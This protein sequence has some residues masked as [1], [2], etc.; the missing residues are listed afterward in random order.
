MRMKN[1][2]NKGLLLVLSLA[3]F[4]ACDFNADTAV[5]DGEQFA[6]FGSDSYFAFLLEPQETLTIE[7]SL[8][9][10]NLSDEAQT[11][12]FTVLTDSSTAQ[13]GVHYDLAS[14]SVT[15][16]AGAV[17]ASFPLTM[18]KAA[19]DNPVSLVLSFGGP[20]FNQTTTVTIQNP[21]RDVLLGNYALV[22]PWY[23]GSDA[24]FAQEVVIGD[25]VSDV[26]A[27]NMLEADTD[28]TLRVTPS[29]DDNI[30]NIGV[31]RQNAW[32]SGTFGQV[33]VE[34]PANGTFN[35]TTGVIELTLGHFIPD[36]RTF[37]AHPL[38][39]TKTN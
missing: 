31:S 17:S 28:I 23:F 18:Y 11:V 25:V 33:T 4:T 19:L 32:T 1:L 10:N 5:Y 38:T 9:T 8:V 29:G 2:Y 21:I 6:R 37:G 13:A 7:V 20:N 30:Y 27:P 22:Y 34:S 26:L 12:V 39:M 36:G 14:T 15:I 24:A 3:L 35:L 16:P